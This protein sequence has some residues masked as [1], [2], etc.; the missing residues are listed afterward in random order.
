MAEL[1]SC[2]I[3]GTPYLD[4][5]YL[6]VMDMWPLEA[7]EL[8][9]IHP[10]YDNLKQGRWTTT[11]CKKCGYISY[12]PG[13]ACPNCW[14]DELEWV[15]LP[16]TAKVV[17]VNEQA[18][19]PTGFKAPLINAWLG[20]DKAHPLKHL[21]VRVINCASGQL[22]IGDEVQFVSFEVDAHP[23]DVKKESKICELYYYAFEP[24]NK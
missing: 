19:P 22:K 2:Q 5:K 6:A 17:A 21:F 13:V 8:N 9:R 1:K 14:S 12:P 24:V 10:F 4:G 11:K 3:V 16:K 23:I 20:F 18:A 7:P 15:D